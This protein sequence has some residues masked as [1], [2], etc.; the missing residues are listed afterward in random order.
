MSRGKG[1]EPGRMQLQ[2]TARVVECTRAQYKP[3]FRVVHIFHFSTAQTCKI[4]PVIPPF[5]FE[6][7]CSCARLCIASLPGIATSQDSDTAKDLVTFKS[8]HGVH[9]NSSSNGK[10]PNSRGVKRTLRFVYGVV[11]RYPPTFHSKLRR[12]LV[13]PAHTNSPCAP[14]TYFHCLPS[15]C[16]VPTRSCL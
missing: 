5:S 8:C 7:N 13:E 2:G 12:A 14:R 11:P 16:T 4:W 10:P 3:S 15:S 9:C 6:T 1:P